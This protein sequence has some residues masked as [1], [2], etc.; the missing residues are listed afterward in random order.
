VSVHVDRI[1]FRDEHLL[2]VQKRAQELTVKAPGT[3]HSLPLLDFLKK[4]M[5]ELHPLNRLDFETSG[6][7]VFARTKAV[8]K[9][10]LDTDFRGWV[11]TYRAIVLGTLPPSG[12]IKT[13]LPARSTGGGLVPACSRFTVLEQFPTAAFVEVT[14]ETGRHHQIRRHFAGIGH[15]LALDD[16]YGQK[17]QNVAFARTYKFQRFFLH[18]WSLR[19][20]HPVTGT[21]VTISAPL[22]PSFEKVLAEL[23]RRATL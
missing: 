1:L 18:A 11:K 13:P 23:R 20:P 19:F 3:Q 6:I 21:I 14:I 2:A 10:V 7:V 4:E 8:L 5:G 12:E 17:P 22:P 15:A 16:V 9:S